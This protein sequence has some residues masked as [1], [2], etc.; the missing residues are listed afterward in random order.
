MRHLLGCF[1]T[2][3]MERWRMDPLAKKLALIHTSPTLTP[4][5]TALCSQFMPETEI[6]HMVDESLIKDTIREGRLQRLRAPLGGMN[7]GV[8]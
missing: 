5:F 8:A 1:D 2:E 4:M 6:F 7:D 3:P